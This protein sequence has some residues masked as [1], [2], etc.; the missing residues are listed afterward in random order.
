[1]QALSNKKVIAVVGAGAMGAGIAQIAAAYGH[2]VKLMD[3]NAEAIQKALEGLSAG[4]ARQ[5]SRGKLK[6]EE[7]T[8]ILNRITAVTEL[9]QLA[10]ASLVIEAVVENLEVK[11][12]IFSTLEKVC[13]SETLF[14]S[15]TSS[16]SITQLAAKLEQ[17]QRLAGMHFFNPPHA[18]KLVE[19]IE[20]LATDNAMIEI[21]MA[22]A[23]AWGKT[24]VRTKSTPGFIVNR[25]AR[26]F[27]AEAL[28]AL[29]DNI[30]GCREIDAVMTGSGG[31]RMGPFSLMDLIGHDVNYAVTESVFNAYY[32]DARF[33]PSVIQRELVNG[34][35]L[36][37][38]TGKGFYDYSAEL[39]PVQFMEQVDA[40][41]TITICG[42]PVGAEVIAKAA[43]V[44]NIEIRNE[45]PK[46]DSDYFIVSNTRFAFTDGKTATE[47][48]LTQQY[49]K[50]VLID[51]TLDFDQSTTI[52]LA[53]SDR[54]GDD[55]LEPVAGFFQQLGKQVIHVDDSPAMLVMRTVCML[56]NEAADTI[57]EG[58]CH[59]KDLDTAMQL[60]TNYPKGPLAWG[61]QI[62]LPRVLFAVE[63]LHRWYGED[64][65]RSS[66]L[67][68]RLVLSEGV[69]HDGNE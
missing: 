25:A 53:C 43:K 50:W 60:G 48:G 31:F 35:F 47:I 67:L 1:M 13:S 63:Q 44:A 3:M 62:T 32:Q 26:P 8:A 57:K 14:A 28:R 20:G 19:V 66:T 4:L 39:E 56:V 34:G 61:E 46:G 10:D 29:Q 6:E 54:A 16:I 55:A 17:P 51:L 18:M 64:R 11:Q 21:L 65:Y 42:N 33:K 58:V 41:A 37:K 27:Y 52:A 23:Q 38:K 68:R 45:A 36:G 22:T 49:Y 69:F 7:A 9:E 30:A 15:N 2:P 5:V 40:P 24:P 59:A 12:T